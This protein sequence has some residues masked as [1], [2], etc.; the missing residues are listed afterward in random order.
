[1]TRPAESRRSPEHRSERSP[2]DE[3]E[4][5]PS[6]LLRPIDPAPAQR[7]RAAGVGRDWTQSQSA[8]ARRSTSSATSTSGS[9]SRSIASGRIFSPRSPTSAR[10]G[11]GIDVLGVIGQFSGCDLVQA[12]ANPATRDE[13]L[14]TYVRIFGGAV[15]TAHTSIP[16]AGSLALQVLNEPTHFLGIAPRDYVRDLLRPAYYHLKEDD[17]AL[18]VVSAAAIGSAV[19]VLQSRQMI[20]AG[21]ELYCDRVAFHLYETDLL[22]E[23]AELAS[24]PVWVTESGSRGSS[25]HREWMTASFERIRREVRRTERIFWYDLFDFDAG[26]FRLIDLAEAP[27]G[28]FEAVSESS[29]AIEWLRSNVASAEGELPHRPLS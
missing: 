2:V 28:S 29:S 20:E 24:K 10:R 8:D 25:T 12:L 22:S 16:D 14:E 11:L 3:A 19:G 9:P 27:D 21:L 23:V 18:T 7:L 1:V 15:L 13:V 26:G 5:R 4:H 17:P 6:A